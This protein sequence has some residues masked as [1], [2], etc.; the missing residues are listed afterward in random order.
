[1]KQDPVKKLERTATVTTLAGLFLAYWQGVA[2]SRQGEWII[3]AGVCLTFGVFDTLLVL[4]QHTKDP[5]KASPLAFPLLIALLVMLI[6]IPLKTATSAVQY[7]KATNNVSYA[8]K[9]D[10]GIVRR[11]YGDDAVVLL[12]DSYKDVP[13]TVIDKN[14]LG[15]RTSMHRVVL[16]EEL[17]EIRSGAFHFCKG[18]TEL[19]LPDGLE[20]I[21]KNAFSTCTALVQVDGGEALSP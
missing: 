4:Y 17:K 15:A 20:V 13:I 16:P 10:V 2:Q 3:L 9:K 11:V 12:G 7:Y 6:L 21:G 8:V 14:A 18:L 5:S 19:T 1:M